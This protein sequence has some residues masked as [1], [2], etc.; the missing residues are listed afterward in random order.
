MRQIKKHFDTSRQAEKYLQN[1]YGM[2]DYVK[3]VSWPYQEKG[4]Y[5]FEVQ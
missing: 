1:L 2:Y 3:L 4:M 5:T